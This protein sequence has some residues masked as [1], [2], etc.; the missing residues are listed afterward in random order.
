MNIVQATVERFCGIRHAQLW[1]HASV[2]NV[3]VSPSHE[4]PCIEGSTIRSQGQI[5]DTLWIVTGW[6]VDSM[7]CVCTCVSVYACV[8]AH[9]AN[10]KLN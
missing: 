4:A 1:K 3:E 10:L 9:E 6:C 2:N 8:L 7:E 5:M